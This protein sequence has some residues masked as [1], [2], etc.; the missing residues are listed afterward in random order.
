MFASQLNGS[1]VGFGTTVAEKCLISNRIIAQPSRQ[2]SLGRDII[3]VGDVIHLLHLVAN[4]FNQG[5]VGMA[6]AAG[7]N[8]AD[9]IQEIF[10]VVCLEAAS[11][12]ALHCQRIASGNVQN[13]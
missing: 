12:T 11:F 1:F 10:S 8:S 9:K 13:I 4:G 6:Q 7:S 5:R 2:G 3:E